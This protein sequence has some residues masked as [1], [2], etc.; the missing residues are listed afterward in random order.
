MGRVTRLG[1]EHRRRSSSTAP[2]GSAPT[3][4]TP[5]TRAATPP[6]RASA[7]DPVT[8]SPIELLW[9]KGSGGDL[10]TLTEAGL[11]VLRLD[12]L[13]ALVDVYPGVEQRGRAWS[14]RSTT[15]CSAGRGRAL[16]RHRDA[17]ARRC[18]PRRPPP[19]R[20]RDRLRDGGRRRGADA[21]V[22]R[23]S[24]GVGSVAAAGV[25]ARPRH[26][27]DPARP[28]R[29][30]RR[31]PRR[32]RDHGLGRHLRRLRGELARDHPDRRAVHRRATAGRTRSARSS[33]G[34]E[35]LPAGASAARGPPPCC[36]SSAASP[37]PTARRSATTRTPTSSSTSSRAR[38]SRGSPRSGRR[39]RTTSCGRRSGR[40]SLDLPPTAPLE[41]LDAR[42][43]E[44]HAAYRDEY[45][46]YYER[47][48]DAGQP[49]DARRRTR[50][51]CSCRASGCSAS[52]PNK[53]TARV[54]GEFYV[55]AINVMRGAEALSHLRA[56]PRVRE[57][58]DR[59]LGARGGEARAAARSRSRSRR[60]SRS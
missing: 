25:P 60:G 40:W 51:S 19:P 36:R 16:D 21:R 46:A 10:G 54:A 11:A 52:A 17:R 5:T 4:G 14:P 45:R 55:N 57:V 12:R 1:R 15:A 13:R 34:Y 7:I 20:L 31:D 3:R 29:G 56:D 22:L 38:P 30:D 49:A 58:P 35:P 33:P 47:H 50:R 39:A 2:T 48:A 43:R 9:V 8:G 42:L 37:R 59:V 44:L 24:R 18:R 6:P 32:A 27:G 23:R 53:Q 26:R 41:E 28:T